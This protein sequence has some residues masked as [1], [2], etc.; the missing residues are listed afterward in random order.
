MINQKKRI[1]NKKITKDEYL[2]WKLNWPYTCD[3]CGKR[4]PKYKWRE[5]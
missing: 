4:E 2:E 5:S 3:D 1:E